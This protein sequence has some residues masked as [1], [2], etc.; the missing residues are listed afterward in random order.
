MNSKLLHPMWVVG[1][2][3]GESC[4]RA[5]VINNAKLRFKIQIQI[6]FLITQHKRDEILL[7]KFKDFFEC[8]SVSKA[9]G[10]NDPTSNTERFRVRKLS[11]LHEKIIPFFEQ[12]SLQTKKQTEFLRFRELCNLLHQKVHFTEE[13]FEHCLKLARILPYN[14]TDL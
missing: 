4:F 3:D 9:K 2:V 1:F 5:S 10:K 6:E 11:D 14:I 13:G 12:H 7:H 8:G